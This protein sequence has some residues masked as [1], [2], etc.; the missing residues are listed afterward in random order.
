[1]TLVMISL[2]VAAAENDVIGC[3]N[4]IV[5]RLPDDM[6]RFKALTR[7]HVVIMGRK[8]YESL[9]QALPERRNIVVT[10]HSGFVAKGCEVAHSLQATL[11]VVGKEEV[12][13][14]G[15]SKLYRQCWN[16]ADRLYLT[17]VH[18]C[19]EGDVFIP[20]VSSDDWKEEEYVFCKADS[21]NEYDYSFVTYVRK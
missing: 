8:T 11:D 14:I 3:N 4:R 20:T 6:K 5:W 15:G 17:R 18:A 7:G 9:G 12:F 10:H 2:I 16:K 13:V 1:M 19:V 21:R